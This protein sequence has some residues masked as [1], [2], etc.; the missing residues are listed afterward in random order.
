[1]PETFKSVEQFVDETAGSLDTTEVFARLQAVVQTAHDKVAGR[2]ELD[3]D[4]STDRFEDYGK[5]AGLDATVRGY[6]GPEVDWLV[7][8]WVA[9][10]AQSFTNLHLTLWL[11]PQVRVPHLAIAL[12]TF[13]VPWCY[14]DLVPRSD[15]AVDLDSLDRYYTPLN[16]EHLDVRARKDLDPFVSRALYV[17]QSLSETAHCFSAP[18]VEVGLTAIEELTERH[19]DRWLRFVDVA[20]PTPAG[21][22]AALAGRDEAVRRNIA[23]LDPANSMGVRYFGQETTDALV[24]A[25]W[26]GDRTSPR[27]GL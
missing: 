16:E 7:H 8:S 18:D 13:P 10:H 4:S 6:V 22:R 11:G 3:R 26:G 17:R 20:E 23:E 15:L 1:M 24:R 2:F 9:N 19:V 14:L 21:E 12:G 25:L 5:D 27:P